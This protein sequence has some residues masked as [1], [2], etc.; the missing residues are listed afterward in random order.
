MPI[1]IKIGSASITDPDTNAD[2]STNT[3]NAVTDVN[4]ISSLRS[5]ISWNTTFP[6]ANNA[7]NTSSGTNPFCVL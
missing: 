5:L 1:A 7:N 2:T 4:F 3:E 6:T